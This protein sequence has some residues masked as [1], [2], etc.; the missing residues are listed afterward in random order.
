MIEYNNCVTTL[1][2]LIAGFQQGTYTSKSAPYS[3]SRLTQILQALLFSKSTKN[4]RIG[5]LSCIW[6]TE[7]LFP[8]VVHSLNYTDR[9]NKLED[10]S[11]LYVNTDMYQQM[12]ERLSE[13]LDITRDNL[14]LKQEI[15]SFRRKH[16]GKLAVLKDKLGINVTVPQFETIIKSKPGTREYNAA[17]EH[18][19][20]VE[21][22]E[23]L[24]RSNR[25][26][27]EQIK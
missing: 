22:T 16:Q 14:M 26:I 27:E 21:K 20:F 18:K 5:F 2:N 11:N 9:F 4:L 12:R 8:E 3:Q 23:A 25:D 6:P 13:L 1:A 19:D 17:R 15:D 24:A 7:S 10:P